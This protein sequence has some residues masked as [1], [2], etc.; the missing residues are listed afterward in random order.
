MSSALLRTAARCRSALGVAT[1]WTRAIHPSDHAALAR[2]L[3][4]H[5]PVRTSLLG[6]LYW[7][8][9]PTANEPP[10]PPLPVVVSIVSEII[11]LPAFTIIGFDPAALQLMPKREYNPHWR[12]RKNKHG[13]LRRLS[14]ASGRQVLARRKAKGRKYLTV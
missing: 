11:N 13:F 7:D 12:K 3:S 6:Q 1:S 2:R 10:L 14:T 4:P 9:V 8:F 5:T